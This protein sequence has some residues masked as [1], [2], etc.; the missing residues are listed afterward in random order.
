M[1]RMIIFLMALFAAMSAGA[2]DIREE[3]DDPPMSF[4]TLDQNGDGVL[5]EMEVM[6]LQ[7]DNDFEGVRFDTLDENDDSEVSDEEWEEYF[8][9]R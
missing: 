3:K 5:E 1:N 6:V 7:D 4:D 2:L 9:N 8:R